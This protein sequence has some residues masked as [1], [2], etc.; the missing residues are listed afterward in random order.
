MTEIDRAIAHASQ[1]LK[2]HAEAYCLEITI[3]PLAWRMRCKELLEN[4]HWLHFCRLYP[5]PKNPD[6]P[7]PPP[8]PPFVPPRR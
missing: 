2:E 4:L 1:L 5:L 6:P 8:P 7:I 3:E